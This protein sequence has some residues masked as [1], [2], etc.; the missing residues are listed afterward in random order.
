MSIGFASL[1]CP[2]GKNE[3]HLHP[4]K[5]WL[6]NLVLQKHHSTEGQQ[7]D[8]PH[9]LSSS[10]QTIQLER[11]VNASL[12]LSA[13]KNSA[14]IYF[15]KSARRHRP[16]HTEWPFSPLAALLTAEAQGCL[17]LPAPTGGSS[18]CKV[19]TSKK[20]QPPP[21]SLINRTFSSSPRWKHKLL[22]LT[23]KLVFT[24]RDRYE[25]EAASSALVEWL[26]RARANNVQ[27]LSQEAKTTT[28]KEGLS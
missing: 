14:A 25:T 18:R 6:Q 1:S 8:L 10:G 23:C 15:G 17:S 19:T 12:K 20:T 3:Q 5:P 4:L 16:K 11:A 7:G 26:T 9:P 28:Q 2:C 22:H 24:Q 27:V 13:L 21:H